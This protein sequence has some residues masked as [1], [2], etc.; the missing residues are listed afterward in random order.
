MSNTLL[1]YPGGK[2]KAASTIADYFPFQLKEI[3]S[4]F[5]GG[6][7]VEFELA[8]RGH[9]I[10]AAD[11]FVPLVCFWNQVKYNRE[12]LSDTIQQYLGKMTKERFRG[13]Q[14]ILLNSWELALPSQ[15]DR[16]L[17]NNPFGVRYDNELLVAS[18]FFILNRCSFSGTTM[19][20]G[21]SPGFPRFTQKSIDKIRDFKLIDNVHSI[22]DT[23]FQTT[24]QTFPD[25]WL[26]CDP[27]YM[28]KN[29]NL[30]GNRGNLHDGFAHESLHALLTKRDRWILSYNDCPEIRKMYEGYKIIEPKWKYGLGKNKDSKEILIM[31]IDQ[32][33]CL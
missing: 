20:G 14:Q 22:T 28:I 16:T 9:T 24:I 23:D 30:Y 3:V 31:P 25:K 10:W 29:P 4:P 2:T 11:A 15:L 1:R 7:A 32:W 6:G 17:R 19:S 8:S 12:K 18:I 13:L 21:C 33:R 27:P 5:F 26:Y